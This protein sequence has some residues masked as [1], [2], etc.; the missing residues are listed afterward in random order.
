MNCTAYNQTLLF[1]IHRTQ[2]AFEGLKQLAN[3][4]QNTPDLSKIQLQHLVCLGLFK[5][6]MIINNYTL[7]YDISNTN[8]FSKVASSRMNTF[9]FTFINVLCF[10]LFLHFLIQS[11]YFLYWNFCSV[12]QELLV[13][14]NQEEEAKN[15]VE[16][17]IEGLISSPSW[18]FAYWR[19]ESLKNNNA[20]VVLG[21]NTGRPLDPE[22]KKKFHNIIW[23]KAASKCE[24]NHF[25]FSRVEL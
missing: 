5:L 2:L 13:Q 14:H 21:H 10:F 17:C 25:S 4:F 3:A 12:F 15:L 18:S 1:G 7:F 9:H 20:L 11:L 8:R 24:V 16:H 19:S 22:T 23:D 6:I